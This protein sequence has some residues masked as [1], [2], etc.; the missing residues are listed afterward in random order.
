MPDHALE[1]SF[2][3][4]SIRA[5]VGQ[6]EALNDVIDIHVLA[7]HPVV[8]THPGAGAGFHNG[9]EMRQVHLVQGMLV[10]GLLQ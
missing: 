2:D 6:W 3:E 10:A 1:L 4:E 7:P 5:V 8:G 9:L